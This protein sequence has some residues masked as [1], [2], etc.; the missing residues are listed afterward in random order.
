MNRYE[1]ES[2]E[3]VASIAEKV[4]TGRPVNPVDW[5]RLEHLLICTVKRTLKMDALPASGH[6]AKFGRT[7]NIQERFKGCINNATNDTY[8]DHVANK[9]AVFLPLKTYRHP[10]HH[11]TV[12]EIET[13]LNKHKWKHL[14]IFDKYGGQKAF[15]AK[16]S[17][18]YFFY[19]PV[20]PGYVDKSSLQRRCTACKVQ[21]E[22][23]KLNFCS[24]ECGKGFCS[25]C[26]AENIHDDGE[27]T[28]SACEP[29]HCGEHDC[30][31]PGCI[32]SLRQNEQD[33][34][35]CNNEGDE[36]E[37][38]DDEEDGTGDDR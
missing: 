26:T 24:N 30:A 9:N 14:R 18:L 16:S 21:C 25:Q 5:R 34:A 4:C 19:T 22:K 32:A 6:F 12:V 8:S 20:S 13:A 38:D 33:S 36:D 28:C 11:H 10:A 17:S 29:D 37:D 2:S 31:V 23:D 15:E 27:D 3:I 7:S 1:F 35:L